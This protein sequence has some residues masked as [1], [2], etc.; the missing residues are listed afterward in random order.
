MNGFREKVLR[1]NERTHVRTRLLRSQTTVGRETKKSYGLPGRLIWTR[2]L[3]K[4][5]WGF[6]SSISAHHRQIE[7][8]DVGKHPVVRKLMEA[9]ETQRPPEQQFQ[10]V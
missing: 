7:G 8:Q 5:H 3:R 9:F 4:I 6:Q 1:T 10:I 2:V